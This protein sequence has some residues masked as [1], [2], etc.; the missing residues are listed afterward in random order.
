MNPAA[1]A[2]LVLPKDSSA[3]FGYFDDAK[4]SP[5][6]SNAAAAGPRFTPRGRQ[7]VGKDDHR[8]RRLQC[9]RCEQRGLEAEPAAPQADRDQAGCETQ[10]G[11]SRP[12][13]RK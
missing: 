3:R 1:P 10:E 12:R 7:R 2:T 6:P 8:E 11:A 13:A 9:G 5:A 4:L